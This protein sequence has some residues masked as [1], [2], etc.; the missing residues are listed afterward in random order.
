M[1][2]LTT[3]RQAPSAHLILVAK[4]VDKDSKYRLGKFATW[5]DGTGSPWYIPDLVT[6]RDTLLAN[7]L[8]TTTVSAPLS[9]VRARYRSLVKDRALFFSMVPDADFVKQKAKVDE[10]VTRIENAI[11]PDESKVTTETVQDVTDS[12]HLRLASGQASALISSP[13]LDDLKGLRDCA[14]IALL[15]CTGIREQELSNLVVNDLRQTY[16]GELALHVREGKGCKTRLV[17]YGELSWCLAIVER[18]LDRAGISEGPVFKG[19]YRGTRK[20][21]PGKLSV[22]AIEYILDD[23]PIMIDGVL[24]KV[25]PHDCRRT[26]ARRL[27]EAGLG[28]M[29]VQQNL[30]HADHK[31]TE[32]Y[33]G[34]LDASKRRPPAVYTF[35]LSL[36]NERY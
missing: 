22:R 15:L 17:P 5:L 2:H 4:K 36:L 28:L 21:R 25:K 24:R 20:L 10:I 34:T 11:D 23:Y 33:I 35:D 26:Y 8:A 12:A 27:Y 32:K 13:D 29:E 3:T 18:W 30:G 31:T 1:T 16:G 19:L 7:G 6:Y 9:T 14:V